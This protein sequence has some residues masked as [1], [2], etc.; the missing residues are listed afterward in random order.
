VA[1]HGGRFEEYLIL[2]VKFFS[3]MTYG[4]AE[5][6]VPPAH[7]GHRR[8]FGEAGKRRIVEEE[9]EEAAV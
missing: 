4:C 1:P 6:I 5:T 3:H 8:K 9:E 2:L 7:E